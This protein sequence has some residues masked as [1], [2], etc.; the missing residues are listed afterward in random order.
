MD[1]SKFGLD[2]GFHDLVPRVP[3]TDE[4]VFNFYAFFLNSYDACFFYSKGRR[5][6]AHIW[7][8]WS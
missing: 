5:L 7:K 6:F 8:K 3:M 4:E 2:L 1:R